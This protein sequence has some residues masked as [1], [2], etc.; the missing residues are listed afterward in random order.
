MRIK[1]LTGNQVGRIDDVAQDFGEASVWTGAAELA[2]VEEVA[3]VAE[4]S[5]EAAAPAP[6][7]GA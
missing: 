4:A 6:E 5:A 1:W 2:P 3:V 7:A